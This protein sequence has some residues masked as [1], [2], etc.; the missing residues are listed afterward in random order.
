VNVSHPIAAALLAAA[1]SV[2]PAALHAQAATQLVTLEVQAINQLNVSGTPSALVVNT[3]TA[4]SAPTSVTSSTTTW[5]V[6]TNEAGRKVTA[7]LNSALP[8]GVTLA[9][10]LSA[11]GG[12]ASV[13]AVPLG[14]TAA[15]VVTGLSTLNA[16]GLGITYT[17]SATAAAGV[18][19]STTRTVTFTLVAGT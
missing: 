13:G 2:A 16:T 3:A 9:V 10:T 11:P 12:A 14:T 15:D 1:A 6:T 17:L 8:S 4:G 19:A 18:V 5:A 7:S